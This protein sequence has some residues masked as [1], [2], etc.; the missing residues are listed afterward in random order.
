MKTLLL[1]S[2][3]P[4][5]IP[6]QTAWYLADLESHSEPDEVLNGKKQTK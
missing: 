2:A 3:K 6:A 5:A 1:L 4:P